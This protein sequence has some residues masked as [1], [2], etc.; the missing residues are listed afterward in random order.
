MPTGFA[1]A[2]WVGLRKDC[3]GTASIDAVFGA[4]V[5]TAAEGARPGSDFL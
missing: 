2:T 1:A 4:D 5:G 3:S